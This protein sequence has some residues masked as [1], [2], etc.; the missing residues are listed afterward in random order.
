MIRTA[1]DLTKR[2]RALGMS[3]SILVLVSAL[4][5]FFVFT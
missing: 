5:E 3:L 1:E 2:E 4:M